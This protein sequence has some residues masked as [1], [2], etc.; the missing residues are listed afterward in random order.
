MK[1][2]VSLDF[3]QE[4]LSQHRIAM[5]G[6]SRNPRHFS[7][8]L[9]DEFCRRGYEMVAVHP[10]VDK[11]RG[12]ACFQRVQ[13]V[14]PPVVNVLLMTTGAATDQVVR[15]CA[16]AGVRRVW[17][18]RAAGPG[19]LTPTAIE[20]CRAHNMQVI[21]GDCPFM[22]F[23]NPGVLHG[24]HRLLRKITGSYPSHVSA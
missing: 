11:L 13:E 4:F 1:P 5:V 22:Y 8:V 17:F 9:F 12:R 19:S 24:A 10:G 20:F 6:L 23:P 14:T 15:D 7:S 3:I 2:S 18:Y 21:P 16:E